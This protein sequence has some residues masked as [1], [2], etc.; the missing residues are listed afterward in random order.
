M[1]AS[2]AGLL[3]AAKADALWKNAIQDP[4]FA[5]QAERVL[6]VYLPDF[7]M[8]ATW[9]VWQLQENLVSF[10]IRI[11]GAE[12]IEEFAMMVGMGFFVLTGQRYQMVIP[13]RLNMAKVKSA[14]LKFVQTEDEEYCLHPEYLVAT[15]P[16]AE[17]KAWQ[18]RLR[19]M[20]EAHRCA[21]MLLLLGD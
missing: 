18:K 4:I 1:A 10:M 15:M 12:E 16:Y 17:A 19:D 3:A 13:A 2:G 5:M 20:D 7:G 6:M 8:A 11:N 9:L 14:V 21:D